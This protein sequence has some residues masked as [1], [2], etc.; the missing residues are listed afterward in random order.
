MT[1]IDKVVH[2]RVYII[3]PDEVKKAI[4]AY[5]EDM[6][7]HM[8][9]KYTYKMQTSGTCIIEMIDKVDEESKDV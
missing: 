6:G 4:M 9:E 1:R 5:M 8:T 2:S 7:R 3:E